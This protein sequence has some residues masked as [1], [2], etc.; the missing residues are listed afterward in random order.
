MDLLNSGATS[1]SQP[2][3]GAIWVTA[4]QGTNFLQNGIVMSA[5]FN[6]TKK[7]SATTI[8]KVGTKKSI[9]NAN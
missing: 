3:P 4:V 9:A 2:Q 5:Y 8:G 1:Y 7:H 6:P